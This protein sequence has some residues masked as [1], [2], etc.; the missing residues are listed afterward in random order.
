MARLPIPSKQ[1]QSAYSFVISNPSFR[2]LWFGQICSQ[3]AI[4]IMMFVL[5][6]HVYQFTTSTTAVSGLYLSF[7]IPAL[8]FGM[9]AGA[10]VDHFD[11]RFVLVLCDSTRAILAISFLFSSQNLIFVYLLSFVN[12]VVTQFYVPAE[13]PTIPRLVAKSHLVTAN[14]LFSFTYYSSLAVGSILAGPLL[15]LFGPFG[16]FIFISILFLLASF[17]E[18]KLP[19]EVDKR[20][21]ITFGQLTAVGYISRSIATAMNEGVAYISRSNVLKDALLLLTGTQIIIGLLATLGPSFAVRILEIDIH[22]ASVVIVGPVVLGIVVGALW[23][24][25]M[26]YKLGSSRL[27]HYGITS[28]GVLLIAIAVV[29][30]LKRFLPL[31]WFFTASTTFTLVVLL[32]FLLGVANSML[33]VPANSILQKEGEGEMRGRVYGVLTAAV[34]GIGIL[35]VVISGVLADF[36]G[37]GKVIFLLGLLISAYGVYRMR[38][39]RLTG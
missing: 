2:N 13:A 1:V 38:Y 28:A 20:Q 4:A 7:A 8:I 30:R 15:G 31:A 22:N 29:V 11:K 3:L 16:A 25:N 10:I 37:V 35:P 36:F 9:A 26:G 32:F 33:D 5:A 17:F 34:G 27:I 19:R 39:N 14:S 6:L 18:S 12:A 24:G 21:Y 23:V